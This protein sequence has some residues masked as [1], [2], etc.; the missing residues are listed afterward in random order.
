[1]NELKKARVKITGKII[2]VYRLKR[3]NWCDY[4]DCITEYQDNELEFL[5]N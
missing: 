1:M 2:N 4:A 5:T 3:G